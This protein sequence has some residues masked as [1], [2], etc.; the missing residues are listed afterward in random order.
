MGNLAFVPSWV[1]QDL[2]V[3]A[4]CL[5]LAV[6]D[7][8]KGERPGRVLLEMTAFTFAYAA[9]YENFATV[10][11]W[12]GYGPASIMVFN[13]PL[14]VPLV[15][16][17]VVWAGLRLV[18]AIGLRPWARPWAVGLLAMLFDFGLDP[19]ALRDLWA[20]SQGSIAR[21]TW[22]P[23]PG[24][25]TLLGEPVYNFTGWVLLG[26]WAAAALLLGRRWA[27]RR[28][29]RLAETGWPFVAF[30]GALLLLVSPL[31]QFILWLAPFFVRGSPGEWIMLGVNAAGPLLFLVLA[32]KP[33][34]RRPL[35]L[36]RDWPV[37]IAFVAFPLLHLGLALGRSQWEILPAVGGSTLALTL[38]VALAALRG[39]KPARA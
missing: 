9:V 31:S 16:Y 35:E 5:A 26:G 20:A 11:G 37:F 4:A 12:Y 24:D 32:R 2:A 27:D 18:E 21:W 28:T 33:A 13:V 1:L 23:G 25:V 17:L 22:Y 29:G 30:L 34:D 6:W 19:V 39:S 36:V 8:A 14:A 15:E 10:M 3:F 7:I 38:L